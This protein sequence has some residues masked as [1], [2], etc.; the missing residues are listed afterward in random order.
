[1]MAIGVIRDMVIKM[2][3]LACATMLFGTSPLIALVMISSMRI[4]NTIPKKEEKG[5]PMIL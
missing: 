3:V 4:G 5:F 2:V 1:M